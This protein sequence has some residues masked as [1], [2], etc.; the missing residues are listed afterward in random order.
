M[1]IIRKIKD[2]KNNRPQFKFINDDCVRRLKDGVIF[3]TNFPYIY[4]DGSP[5]NDG[6]DVQLF[7]IITFNPNEINLN[8]IIK[9]GMTDHMTVSGCEINELKYE[10]DGVLE[11]I[12]FKNFKS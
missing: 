6:Y 9:S 2:W 10:K 7:N 3:K 1:T 12:T 11:I 5:V 4:E 8:F